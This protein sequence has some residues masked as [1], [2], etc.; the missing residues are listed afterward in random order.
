MDKAVTQ[1]EF[2]ALVGVSQQAVAE[3]LRR[4]ILP[5]GG[6]CHEWLL[7]YCDRLR[8]EAAGR[9]PSDARERRDLAIARQAEAKAALDERELYRQDGLIVDT[10]TVEHAMREWA[11][12]ARSE[13]LTTVDNIITAIESVHDITCDRTQLEEYVTAACSTIGTFALQY[14]SADD[15]DGELLDT[16]AEAATD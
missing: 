2:A 10:A 15:I 5:Q 9:V 1:A 4:R 11:S 7:A 14:A 8:Q 16:E 3:H 13:L 12:L 6:T